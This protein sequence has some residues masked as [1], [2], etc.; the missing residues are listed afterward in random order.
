MSY[1]P[2][3][4]NLN[5]T[6]IAAAYTVLSTDQYIEATLATASYAVT[7]WSSKF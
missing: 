5:I 2:P 6:Q 4:T 7:P 1:I 3:T